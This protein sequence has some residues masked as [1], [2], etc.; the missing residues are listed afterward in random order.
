MQHHFESATKDPGRTQ[1]NSNNSPTLGN[2]NMIYQNY[3]ARN[4]Y[5]NHHLYKTS[6][7]Q[8][9]TSNPPETLNDPTNNEPVSLLKPIS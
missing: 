7:N 8:Q 9:D 4:L 1:E 3:G 6:W 2:P 5:T